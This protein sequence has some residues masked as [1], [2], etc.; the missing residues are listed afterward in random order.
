MLKRLRKRRL[1]LG[2][3]A[4][5]LLVCLYWSLGGTSDRVDRNRVWRVGTD[6]TLPYHA[7]VADG[8]SAPQ[9]KGIAAELMTAAAKRVGVKLSWAV[10][11]VNRFDTGLVDLWPLSSVSGATSKLLVTRPIIRHSYVVVSRRPDWYELSDQPRLA[12]RPSVKPRIEGRYPKAKFRVNLSRQAGLL[13]LCQ[14][15]V[16]GWLV[17][18]R[19]LQAM[20]LNRPQPCE[21]INLSVSGEDLT[22]NELGFGSTPEAWAVA[23]LLRDELDRMIEDGSAHAVIQ[24]WNYFGGGDLDL[25]YREASAKRATA[26]STGLALLLLLLLVLLSWLFYRANMAQREAVAANQAKTNFLANISH[27]IRTPLSGILGLAEVLA[28]SNLDA[29]QS[30]LLR[31]LSGSGRNLLAIVNDVLDLARVTR[32]KFVLR[33]ELVA[34]KPMFEDAAQLFQVAAETKKLTFEMHGLESLPAWI[35]ADPVRLRQVFFNLVGNAVKFT[36]RG[37]VRVQFRVDATTKH[38]ELSVQDTGIGMTEAA[39]TRLFEKFYQADSS[40]SRRFGGTGLGL[41]IVK[42]IVT[43][44][45]GSIEVESRADVGSKFTV[46]VPLEIAAAPEQAVP[47]IPKSAA[48]QGKARIL[49]VEDNAVNQL[50]VRSLLEM[51]GHTVD[52]AADGVA[53][54]AA[55]KAN[56]YDLVLMDCQ[57]PNLDGYQ[58][59]ALIRQAEENQRHTPIVALTAS[60]LP[61]ERERCVEAGMDDFLAK[62]LQ[63]AELR[64]IVESWL[65]SE[66]QI[67]VRLQ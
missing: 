34:P 39:R 56:D 8:D 55:W 11:P 12:A 7:L 59:T 21:G 66:K 17:E 22:T 42:E 47:E 50:V 46:R 52:C 54:V 40:I 16:D 57:M 28:A 26:L 19:P 37:E 67:P 53:G 33:P 36:D 63:A 6:N 24:E 45:G 48:T 10:M 49:V 5:A 31:S 65:K 1:L 29:R 43:A 60:A 44:M 41:S 23:Q 9:P 14:G 61:G 3:G 15:E 25:I 20:L 51:A 62:P 35:M 64:R 58:A 38:L 30:D 18:A 13:A 32:G 2:A 4:N 27:E